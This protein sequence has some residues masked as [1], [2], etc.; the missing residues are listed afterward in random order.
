MDLTNEQIE[1]IWL[2]SDTVLYPEA[3]AFMRKLVREEDCNP[4]PNSQAAGLLNIAEGAKYADLYALIIHQR[5]R[6]WTGSKVDIKT[7]YTDLEKHFTD[8]QKRRLRDEFQLVTNRPT[9]SDAAAE[10][11]ELMLLLARDFIQHL[12]AE[13]GILAGE[14]KGRR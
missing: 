13:N 8:M 10:I 14:R 11:D 5:D 9:K 1:K 3:V 4:L 12:I 2:V 6:N 7:F